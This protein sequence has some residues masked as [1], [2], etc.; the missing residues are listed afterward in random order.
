MMELEDRIR[1]DGTPT[2]AYLE[3][4]NGSIPWVSAKN[5]Q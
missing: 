1:T 5:H 4:W 3:Y 2:T